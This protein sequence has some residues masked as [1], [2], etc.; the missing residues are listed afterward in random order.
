V[1]K[2]FRY[3]RGIVSKIPERVALENHQPAGQCMRA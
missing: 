2:S 1:I 3:S